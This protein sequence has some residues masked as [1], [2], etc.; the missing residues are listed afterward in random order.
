[1][2]GLGAIIAQS[3]MNP[4][5]DPAVRSNMA[6][7]NYFLLSR[8]YCNLSVRLGYHFALAEASFSELLTESYVNFQFQGGAADERR[9]RRRVR[10]LGDT[11]RG[12][13][14]RVDIKGDSLTARIEKRPV[15]YLRERLVILGYLLIHTRQV[16]MVMDEEGFVD[17]Y[18]ERIHADIRMLREGLA[19]E[20]EQG[21]G[22]E[23]A[24]QDSAGR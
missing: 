5:L 7:R 1:M 6:G 13:D 19:K 15:P 16:D 4:Q 9:R 8:N 2:R 17:R 11:L 3:A 12:I 21:N 23:T 10:L 14:F 18:L 20:T 22:T 24:A